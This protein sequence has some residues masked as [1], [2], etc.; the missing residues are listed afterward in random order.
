M[1]TTAAIAVN[2]IRILLSSRRSALLLLLP[3]LFL[4]LLDRFAADTVSKSNI[5]IVIADSDQSEITK[6]IIS[7]I[8]KNPV[9]TVLQA[10]SEDE[11]R[12]LVKTQKAAAGFHFPENFGDDVLQNEAEE[13]VTVWT[14]PTVIST[15]AVQEMVAAEIMRPSASAL[16]AETAV[17]NAHQSSR[18]NAAEKQQLWKEVYEYTNT[19]W[20]KKT[21]MTI[22]NIPVSSLG[23]GTL[24]SG[25]KGSGTKVPDPEVPVQPAAVSSLYLPGVLL[26]LMLFSFAWC[27]WVITERNSAITGRILLTAKPHHYVAGSLLAITALQWLLLA[28]FT[29]Y[30]YQSGKLPAQDMLQQTASLAMYG[31]LVSTVVFYLAHRVRYM[32]TWGM[33]TIT[34]LLLSSL[35]S[36]TFIPTDEITER[37]HYL[38]YVT[39]QYW[40]ADAAVSQHPP[41]ITLFCMAAAAMIVAIHSTRKAGE[42]R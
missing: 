21:L 17:E 14:T 7:A 35:F 12:N 11:A 31:V 37:L 10:D 20:N 40:A 32:R 4:G 26:F 8:Q 36:G 27:G 33:I 16:G 18:M 13:S 25:T 2:R 28:G 22:E 38:A 9:M 41:Y 5:P 6:Q 3:V 34:V 30:A 29:V 1:G 39:P 19:T 23:S 15:A 42:Q 24:G